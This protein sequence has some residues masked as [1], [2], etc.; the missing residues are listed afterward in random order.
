[1]VH[2]PRNASA[3]KTR[4]KAKRRLRNVLI[5]VLSATHT[6]AVHASPSRRPAPVAT[7]CARR[8]WFVKWPDPAPAITKSHVSHKLHHHRNVPSWVG[9]PRRRPASNRPP[10]LARSYAHLTVSGE[11]ARPAR[12]QRREPAPVPGFQRV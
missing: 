2:A 5:A 4:R 11:C 6:G 10:D 12:D 7:G 8:I 9:L 1:M 3:S